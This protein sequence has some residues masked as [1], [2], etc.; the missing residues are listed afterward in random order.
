MA[1]TLSKGYTFGSTEL[2]TN[3]K[4]HTLVDSSTVDMSAPGAIGATTPSTGAFTTLTGT[5]IDGIVGANTPAAGSF[6]TLGATGLITT[7]GQIQFPATANP[8]A[9][10]NTLDDYEEGYHTATVTCSASGSYTVNSS[11]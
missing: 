4:L 7:N 8:S 1:V 10:A 2:V 6:T 5:N 3:T 11:D 9:D